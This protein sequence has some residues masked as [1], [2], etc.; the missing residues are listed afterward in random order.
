MKEQPTN[1]QNN[2]ELCAKDMSDAT[3]QQKID[4]LM[5]IVENELDRDEET[6]DE[7]LIWECM[8]LLEQFSAEP[9]QVPASPISPKKRRMHRIHRPA[10]LKKI[11]LRITAV[12]ATVAMT[13]SLSLYAH[14][15][16]LIQEDQRILDEAISYAQAVEK[17]DAASSENKE[18]PEQIAPPEHTEL[19]ADPL[20]ATPRQETFSRMT[21]LFLAYPTL[22]F[23]YPH[24]NSS[25]PDHLRTDLKYATITYDSEESWVVVL[26]FD[27]PSLKS[28]VIQRQLA[29]AKYTPPS[30]NTTEVQAQYSRYQVSE[31]STEEGTLFETGFTFMGLKYTARALDVETLRLALNSIW[32]MHERYESVEE[33]VDNW[34][35]LWDFHLPSMAPVGY[36]LTRIELH[37]RFNSEWSLSFVYHSGE[38]YDAKYVIHR[39]MNGRL[40]SYRISGSDPN[41]RW[42]TISPIVFYQE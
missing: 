19:T 1:S 24:Q 42:R 5:Q 4:W 27:H 12:A 22:D 7:Q 26:S 25:M 23:L 8:E 17:A 29:S 39:Q 15:Q 16:T 36:K 2:A 33:L 41:L 30:K 31:I 38:N 40:Y 18:P 3:R 34:Q 28:F 35:H 9:A 13:V 10:H 37:H 21:D 11:L 6:R 32:E 14:A 20:T